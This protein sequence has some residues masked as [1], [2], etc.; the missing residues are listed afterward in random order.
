M[1]L[2]FA[3]LSNCDFYPLEVVDRGGETQF[4]RR[5]N[6]VY[7]FNLA[8][9]ITRKNEKTPLSGWLDAIF[10][11]YNATLGNSYLSLDMIINM[12]NSVR[13]CRLYMLMRNY[14]RSV[15]GFHLI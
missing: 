3:T 11:I 15:V 8:V 14:G 12:I 6:K 9:F 5:K 2:K 13:V 10:V 7:I 4:Q 1:S